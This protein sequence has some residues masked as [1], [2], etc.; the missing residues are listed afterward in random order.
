VSD[1]DI[2]I[3]FIHC[4][5]CVLYIYIVECP[6]LD[7]RVGNGKVRVTRPYNWEYW[8]VQE[9]HVPVGTVVSVTCDLSYTG[10][11]SIFCGNDGNWSA[12]LPS[13]SKGEPNKVSDCRDNCTLII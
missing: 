5:N 4:P 9:R 6:E 13:C 12:P 3:G 8:N 1:S 7:A 2:I 11:D 10:D